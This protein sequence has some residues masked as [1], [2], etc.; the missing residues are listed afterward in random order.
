MANTPYDYHH[1]ITIKIPCPK[2]KH[3]QDPYDTVCKEC[4]IYNKFEPMEVT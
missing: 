3:N 4:S 2:C 1:S